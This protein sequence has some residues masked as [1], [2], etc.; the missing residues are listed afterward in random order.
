V[1]VGRLSPEKGVQT[2]LEAWRIVGDRL[3]L[4]I[5]GD[6]PLASAVAAGARE[7]P[8]ISWLGSREP[9]EVMSILRDA[10]CLVFPS[11]CF[12]TFGR[13]VVEAFAAATPAIVSGHGAASELVDDGVTGLHFRPGDPSDLAARVIQLN[14]FAETRAAMRATA[15][16]VFETRY[17][18]DAN[19][20]SLFAIYNRVIAG[21]QRDSR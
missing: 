2:L 10:V 20:E 19:Y 13:A 12:E 6:G 15:R 16:K 17:T 8:W 3:P 21:A 7:M 14:G 1:F 9:H 11:E 4:R 5:I 18:A